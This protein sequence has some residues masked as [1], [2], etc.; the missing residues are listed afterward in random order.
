ML[1]PAACKL[2][3]RQKPNIVIL[4]VFDNLKEHHPAMEKAVKNVTTYTSVIMSTTWQRRTG[5]VD[6]ESVGTGT[7]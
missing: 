2:F 6:S 5:D 4:G 7:T 1:L 3:K